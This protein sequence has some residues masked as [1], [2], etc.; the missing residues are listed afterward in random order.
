MWLSIPPIPVVGDA[1]GCE[2][3]RNVDALAERLKRLAADMDLMGTV[4]PAAYARAE[5]AVRTKAGE[6]GENRAHVNRRELNDL[7]AGA[8]IQPESFDHLAALMAELGILTQFAECV[9]LRDFVV[10]KPQWLTKAISR[11]I[12]KTHHMIVKTP[13]HTKGVYW[14]DGVFLATGQGARRSEALC[15]FDPDRRKLCLEVRAAFPQNLVEM[16]DNRDFSAAPAIVSI[17]PVDGSP[18]NPGNWLSREYVLTPYCEAQGAIHRCQ[19]VCKPFRM[20]R[21]W[22]EKTAPK[23]ALGVRLL[24]AAVQIALA[25]LPL[26]VSPALYEPMKKEADFMKE[27]AKHLKLEGGAASD[28]GEEA[29]DF[30]RARGVGPGVLDFRQMA[31]DDPYRMARFQLAR[32]LEELAPDN[33]RARQWGPLRRVRMGDNTYRWMC[34]EH[35]R[36]MEK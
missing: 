17:A 21:A 14:H 22:W 15:T 3:N 35:A 7:F 2:T 27:L 13:E 6:Q 9:D 1:V 12:V 5:A 28:F 24:G 23:L 31:G 11:V 34:D 4:W 20:P 19:G 29:A 32:L 8:E 18:W 26:A 30:V 33:Y 25:G 36:K 16:L 10:L